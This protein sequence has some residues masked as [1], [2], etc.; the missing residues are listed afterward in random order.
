METIKKPFIF[1]TKVLSYRAVPAELQGS[2]SEA[3]KSF[4]Y[5]LQPS[6]PTC[7]EN[8]EDIVG[9]KLEGKLE[10]ERD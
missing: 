4:G 1:G 5:L 8:V 7:H 6:T 10:V 3:I 9:S 2:R